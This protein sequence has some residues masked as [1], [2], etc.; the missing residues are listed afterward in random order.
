[1]K[2]LNHCRILAALLLLCGGSSVGH[3]Q[4]Y[5]DGI[6]VCWDYKAQQFLNGGVYSRL[7]MLSNGTLAC[8]YSAGNDVFFR[9]FK[10]NR[11]SSAIKVATDSRGLHYYT[12]SELLELADG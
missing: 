2:R 3:A 7:K 10:N 5:Y 9:T 1:M 12:N 4:T 11:W 8:V 6:R